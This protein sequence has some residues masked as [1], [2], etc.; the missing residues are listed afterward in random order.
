MKK[1][2]CC[3][4]VSSL[5]RPERRRRSSSERG[6]SSLQWSWQPGTHFVVKPINKVK[7]LCALE[8]ERV[9]EW[10]LCCHVMTSVSGF[11]KLCWRQMNLSGGSWA[12]W[13]R[14]WVGHLLPVFP[15]VRKQWETL[16]FPCAFQW[17]NSSWRKQHLKKQVLLAIEVIVLISTKW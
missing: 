17:R 15:F 8:H 3:T 13:G 5:A 2:A 7:P 11:D 10:H 6:G 14:S 9:K 4:A 1:P 12:Q 16:V